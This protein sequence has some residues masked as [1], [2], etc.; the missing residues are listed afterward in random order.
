MSLALAQKA[1][2]NGVM[3]AL[4]GHFAILQFL[5][6]YFEI[7]RTIFQFHFPVVV[8]S[9]FGAFVDCARVSARRRYY[10]VLPLAARVRPPQLFDHSL[11][12]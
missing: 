10:V 9:K 12:L 6:H 1:A 2:A 11:W 7:Y 5:L 8:C 4:A 3:T